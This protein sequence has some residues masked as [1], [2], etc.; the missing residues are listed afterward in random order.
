MRLGSKA[1]RAVPRGAVR[2]AGS[3]LVARTTVGI[4]TL[5]LFAL[6]ARLLDREEFGVFGIAWSVS[7]VVAAFVEGGFGMLATRTIAA[8]RAAAGLF[9]GSFVPLRVALS[10]VLLAIALAGYSILG[11]ADPVVVVL[12]A[13][14][15]ANLQVVS[16]A[17]R[18][19]ML[20]IHRNEWVAAHTI[21]ETLFRTGVILVTAS[22]TRQVAD[23]FFAVAIFHALWTAGGWA[24]AWRS[25]APVG[26][27][28]GMRAWRPVLVSSLPF[29]AIVYITA[30]YYNMDILIAS[31]LVPL[32]ALPVIQ[33]AVR[34]LAA[35]DYAPEAAWRWALPRL[36]QSAN[37]H[38]QITSQTTR[39]A[40]ALVILGC[41]VGGL[42]LIGAGLIVPIVFGSRYSGATEFV[43]IVAIAVPMR[44]AAHAYG[45]T[46]LAVG[47]ERVRLLALALVIASGAIV[48][49]ALIA[50]FG[51]L[52]AAI[53]IVLIS[54]ALTLAYW[55][56]LRRS[57]PEL[58]PQ[59]LLA[60]AV[61]VIAAVPVAL[62]L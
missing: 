19:F 33:I 46:L 58:D 14:A 9:F 11:P 30:I 5:I 42:M 8:D 32:T 16:G 43:Q 37:D 48:E 55:I 4:S 12:T 56:A 17:A 59:P 53:G 34:I 15:A 21:L 47:R 23:M 61:F 27:I 18:D 10:V 52:G 25:I 13:T 29:G 24:L 40:W 2:G 45:T 41:A 7:Y 38:P 6:L 57:L 39:L 50:G 3:L 28:A 26:I 22:V 60:I 35:S 51:V 20:A 31:A 54:C 62:L 49:F 44:Y 1:I 36:S